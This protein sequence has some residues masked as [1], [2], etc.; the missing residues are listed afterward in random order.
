M[1]GIADV[2]AAQAAEK[3]DLVLLTTSITK[4]L[5]AFASGAMTPAQAQALLDATNANDATVK[6]DLAAIT[7]AL[8]V[9]PPV[10]GP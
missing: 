10:V 7:A 8:P 1:A 6:S 9:V 2:T 4:L 3:A 5:A